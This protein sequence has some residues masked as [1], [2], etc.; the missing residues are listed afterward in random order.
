MVV[1]FYKKCKP[2]SLMILPSGFSINFLAVKVNISSCIS[3]KFAAV[4]WVSKSPLEY[5]VKYKNE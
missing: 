2:V 5:N 1:F 4:C 3:S